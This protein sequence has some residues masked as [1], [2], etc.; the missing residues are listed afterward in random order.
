MSVVISGYSR[1][2]TKITGEK[3]FRGTERSQ[4]IGKIIR[5]YNEITKN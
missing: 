3:E 1:I 5:A 2:K 4:A